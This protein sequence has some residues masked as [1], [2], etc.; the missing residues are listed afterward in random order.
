MRKEDLKIG[1]RVKI[2]DYEDFINDISIIEAKDLLCSTYS[3]MKGNIIKFI[4]DDYV[5]LYVYD[6]LNYGKPPES[7]VPIKQLMEVSLEDQIK[8]MDTA[9]LFVKLEAPKIYER[10]QNTWNNLKTEVTNNLKQSE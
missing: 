3:D 6:K 8:D 5:L 7:K 10:I 9:M 1:M 4:N 2:R